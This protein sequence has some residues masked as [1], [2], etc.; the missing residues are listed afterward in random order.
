M[1][2]TGSAATVMGADNPLQDD[3]VGNVAHGGPSQ[4]SAPLST[5]V[6]MAQQQQQQRDA[7]KQQF[8]NRP[9]TS[10]YNQA[11]PPPAPPSQTPISDVAKDVAG[12]VARGSTSAADIL[13]N[14][15]EMVMKPLRTAGAAAY[16]WLAPKLGGSAL[17]PEQRNDILGSTPQDQGPVS[18]AVASIPGRNPFN[19]PPATSVGKSLDVPIQSA[20]GG[21]ALGPGGLLRRTAL[22]A[23]GGAAGDVTANQ[24]DPRYAPLVGML[25]NALVQGGGQAILPKPGLSIDPADAAVAQRSQQ[26][27]GI[28]FRAPDLVANS[29]LRTPAQVSRLNDSLRGS[30]VTEMGQNPDTGYAPTTNKVTPSALDATRTS[31]GQVFNDVGQNNNIGTMQ[32]NV[33]LQKLGGLD[34]DIDNVTGV[35][36][37]DR[38]IMRARLGE[39]RSAVNMNTGG[40]SGTDY[41]NLTQTGSRLDKLAGDGNSGIAGIGLQAMDALHDAMGRSLPPQQQAALTQARYQYRLMKTVEPLVNQDRTGNIDAGAFAGRVADQSDLL[42]TGG[43]RAAYSGGGTIGALGDAARLIAKGAP[44]KNLNPIPSLVASPG[45]AVLPWLLG[46]P[47][48][49]ILAAQAAIPALQAVPAAI[50]RG[51]PYANTA[52][53]NAIRPPSPVD[54]G[55][56]GLLSG[57]VT[58]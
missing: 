32:A 51:R 19:T 34:N 37:A 49:E 38:S 21:A 40:M 36:D 50:M 7:A 18:T 39:I 46:R 43:R 11:N 23:A 42:D 3:V 26:L 12:S 14:P 31:T 8:L 6:S 45:A 52:F 24:V 10:L 55:V 15:A 27:F 1:E 5:D 56:R 22:G 33:L 54:Y 9:W 13:L 29:Q 41:L 28:P 25:T 16:D 17:T 44:P 48:P 30:I 4:D 47:L 58:P 53:D 57:A 20:I 35:S 2:P